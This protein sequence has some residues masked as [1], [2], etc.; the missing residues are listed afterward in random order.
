MSSLRGQHILSVSQFTSEDL[1][2][3]FET[4]DKLR[5]GMHSSSIQNKIMACVFY[6]ESTR[7]FASFTS[8]MLRLGGSVIPMQSVKFSS[9]TK[10]E[11]LEDTVRA[12][13]AYCDVIVLRHPEEGSAAVAAKVLKKPLINAGDGTGEHPTQALLDAYT[14]KKE[15]GRLDDL[16]ITMVGDLK[17]GRTVHS[18]VRLMSMYEGIRFTFISPESLRLPPVIMRELRIKDVPC[19]ESSKLEEALSDTDVMY[20]TRIQKERFPSLDEYELVKDS[21]VINVLTLARSPHDLVLMHPL[22][23][24]NEIS[25]GVDADPRAAY[26]RQVENGLYI[27]MALLRAV[28]SDR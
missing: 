8:A 23:R 24:V 1:S 4:A 7:T 16:H 15:K 22:P 10:G 17:Y 2:L 27:R 11:T 9:V 5:A 26:F 21:Y 6:E 14:I 13:E 28:L 20:V 25:M 19:E 3:L 18:L 12:L